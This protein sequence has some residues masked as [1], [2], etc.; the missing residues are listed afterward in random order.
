MF[1]FLCLS[2]HFFADSL[3]RPVRTQE[4]SA[5]EA[6]RHP[7]PA[8]ALRNCHFGDGG[9]ARY[10]GGEALQRRGAGTG[11]AAAVAD[12]DNAPRLRGVFCA[13]AEEGSAAAS[14][15]ADFL[16]IRDVLA[17]EELKALCRTVS[18]PAYAPGVALEQAWELGASGVS[19]I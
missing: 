6:P 8:L 14:A 19:E 7:R 3:R 18:V 15:G 5:T 16:V 10:L 2:S 11:R 17:D 12:A 13:S 4:V 1:T 9:A